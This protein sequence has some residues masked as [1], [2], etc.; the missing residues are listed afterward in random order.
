[1]FALAV[2]DRSTRTLSL[3]RDRMG[4]KPLYYGRQGRSFLFGSELK[5]LREHP[6]FRAEIDRVA[7]AGYVRSGYVHAPRSIY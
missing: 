7:L 1:M 3:A 6:E 2:W 5:A 4:E